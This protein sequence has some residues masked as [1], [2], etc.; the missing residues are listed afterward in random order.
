[1]SHKRAGKPVDTAYE[2]GWDLDPLL[3]GLHLDT[4]LLKQQNAM[5]LM[6]LKITAC[7]Y[8]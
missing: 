2:T 4:A 6:G 5:G 8:S 1:M 3:Q 7:M